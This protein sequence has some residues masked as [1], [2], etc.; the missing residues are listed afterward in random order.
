MAIVKVKTNFVP[1]DSREVFTPSK[2]YECDTGLKGDDDGGT[3][4][5]DNGDER[6]IYIP[7][8]AHLHNK[9]WEIVSD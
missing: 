5:G 6:Y 9:S 3:V 8:C 2:V 7:S 1:E 4:I